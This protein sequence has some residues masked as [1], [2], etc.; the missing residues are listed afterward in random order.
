MG[1]PR[2]G[3]SSVQ[4]LLPSPQ[5]SVIGILWDLES[6]HRGPLR[7]S[8][9]GGRVGEVR[10]LT[11]GPAGDDEPT[12]FPTFSPEPGPGLREAAPL[13]TVRG[14]APRGGQLSVRVT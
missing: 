5:H 4:F 3:R 12:T 6:R 13:R 2:L 7:G 1:A 11:R 9:R 14:P 8:Q 10:C